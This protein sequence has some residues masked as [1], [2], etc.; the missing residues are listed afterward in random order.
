M[1]IRD[2]VWGEW[3]VRRCLGGPTGWVPCA[4]FI[5]SD[6]AAIR[7]AER[8][9]TYVPCRRL[10]IGSGTS[11]T[12][13][14]AILLYSRPFLACH[15]CYCCCSV[16]PELSTVLDQHIRYTPFSVSLFFSHVAALKR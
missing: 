12:T 10:A 15:L 14:A 16:S 11:A 4:V 5:K 7:G 3:G 8:R 9:I 2:S 13:S 1:C 6:V